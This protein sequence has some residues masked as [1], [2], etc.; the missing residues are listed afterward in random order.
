M[1]TDYKIYIF[2]LKKTSLDLVK[3]WIVY[4]F[5]ISGFTLAV[6]V[7]SQ[8]S[9][10]CAKNPLRRERQIRVCSEKFFKAG[11]N[12]ADFSLLRGEKQALIFALWI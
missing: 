7:L 4:L 3:D 12:V 11:K 10:S 9:H 6:N 5:N 2:F 8:V 1:K